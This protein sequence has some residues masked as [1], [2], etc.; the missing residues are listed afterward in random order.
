MKS[1]TVTTNL[2]ND[3]E[4][5]DIVHLPITRISCKSLQRAYRDRPCI[6]PAT[7]QKLHHSSLPQG[8]CNCPHCGLSQLSMQ[9]PLTTEPDDTR[10]QRASGMM[11]TTHE[12]SASSL[13]DGLC[14]RT[15]QKSNRESTSVTAFSKDLTNKARH[16]SQPCEG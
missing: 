10:S 8:S 11:D 2:N 14:H 3:I 15:H 16:S 5:I 12:S 1:A 9:L 13:S 6:P 7:S 4:S